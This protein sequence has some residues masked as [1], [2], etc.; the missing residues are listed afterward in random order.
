REDGSVSDER[1]VALCEAWGEDPNEDAIRVPID[2]IMPQGAGPNPWEGLVPLIAVH[3]ILREGEGEDEGDDKE[4]SV[5]DLLGALHPD[6]HSLDR[7]KLYSDRGIPAT[8]RTYAERLARLVRG[9]K[10]RDGELV[11]GHLPAGIP[12]LD[13]WVASNLVAPRV[14]EGHSDR[15]IHAW[16]EKKHPS[17]AMLYPAKEIA[18]LRGLRLPPPDRTTPQDPT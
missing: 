15:Q 5:D 7:G 1:W 16:M 6:P 2:P 4:G 9:A 18:R 11:R 13:H 3:A 14:E 10:L 8:L 17:L 12:D